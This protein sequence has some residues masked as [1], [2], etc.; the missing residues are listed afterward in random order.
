MQFNSIHFILFLFL[1]LT[2]TAL[3]PQKYRKILLFVGS[4]YF[5]AVWD[6]R[7]LSLMIFSAAVDYVCG[8]KIYLTEN[9]KVRKWYLITSVV[10][11]LAVLG[12]FKYF[13][14][15]AESLQHLIGVSNPVLFNIVLPVGISFYTFQ[16]MSYTIDI[17]RKDIDPV[18]KAID[19]FLFITFFPQI[20]AG[21]IVRAR[22]FLPQLDM[23]VIFKWKNI[24]DGVM[25]FLQGFVKKVLF[26]DL[27][28]RYV[29]P[30]F[31]SPGHY[32]SIECAL[33]VYGFA[34]QIY[35]D[36][37]GYTDMA[38]GVAK[39]FGF[40]LPLNFNHP[41]IATSLKMFWQ[42]WHITLSSWLK[43]YLYIPLG[44]N[45][46]G[47]FIVMRNLVLTMFLGGLWH[48]AQWTFVIW[49][50]YH[51]IL[52]ALEK[53]TFFSMAHT[54][55][56][57]SLFI[58]IVRNFAIFNLICIGWIFFRAESLKSVMGIFGSLCKGT[59]AFDY[60]AAI[61]SFALILFFTFEILS[62]LSEK[63]VVN[64]QKLNLV[65]CAA[66]GGAIPLAFIYSVQNVPFIYFQF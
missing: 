17:Y 25:L 59:F 53:F 37:C 64:M 24:I 51:G 2:T 62:F 14:F 27:L 11:N 10:C 44:G 18:T 13:N 4:C 50:L 1:A 39:M 43:D 65:K 6:Y 8:R 55:E 41:Y 28:A 48:G 12:F 63:G 21:P 32:S 9:L 58:L 36:F 49:G 16:S 54:K 19:F 23:P 38:T 22:E 57:S 35:Y 29:D 26:A 40:Q 66:L 61:L 60:S 33:A 15:F 47:K 46:G 56:K 30:V 20:I 34:F 31:S 45:R 5:Y 3:M 7:F 52:L 42:R